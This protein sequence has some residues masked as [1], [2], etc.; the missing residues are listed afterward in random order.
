MPAYT[1]AGLAAAA[2]G[3]T[4]ELGGRV[5][6][7]RPLSV[8][9]HLAVQAAVRGTAADRALATLAVLRGAFPA[10]GGPLRR[11]WRALRGHDPV[12]RILRLPPKLQREVLAALLALPVTPANDPPEDDPVEATRRLNRLHNAHGKRRGGITLAR[13]ALT[14]ERRLGAG[15]LYNPARWPTTDGYAPAG[16]VLLTY[17]GLAALAA[18]DRLD[19]AAAGSVALGGTHAAR[20]LASWHRA[21]YP[22]EETR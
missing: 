5:Y 19:R 21:A 2:R 6:Q 12:P 7:A 22:D 3:R 14:C 8:V 4:L 13:A 1:A 20:T 18:E 15:W 11:W 17:A 10:P 16:I 9:V